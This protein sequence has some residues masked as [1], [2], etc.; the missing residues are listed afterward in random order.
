LNP[1]DYMLMS[2]EDVKSIQVDDVEEVITGRPPKRDNPRMKAYFVA[3]AT[4]VVV[5]EPFV[6]TPGMFAPSVKLSDIKAG[7]SSAKQRYTLP[8]PSQPTEVT[9]NPEF[10]VEATVDFDTS[11][12]TFSSLKVE[13]VFPSDIIRN[14]G[15]K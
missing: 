1:Y 7:R 10:G 15:K 11:M 8:A 3:K 2:I 13:Q 12:N 14:A 9:I 5:G 6:L 4:V